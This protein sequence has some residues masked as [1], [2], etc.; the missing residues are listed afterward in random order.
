VAKA[1]SLLQDVPLRTHLSEREIERMAAYQF[2]FM[3]E[4][5]EEVRREGTG[6]EEMLTHTSVSYRL[7]HE[8]RVIWGNRFSGVVPMEFSPRS[9]KR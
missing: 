1:A 2:A 8:G 9:I 7:C 5:D 6:S 4:E 3:L